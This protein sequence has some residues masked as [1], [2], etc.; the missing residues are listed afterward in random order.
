[1]SIKAGA[2]VQKGR[3]VV[4][5][6]I[7]AGGP[8]QVSIPEE[9]I[10]ELGNYDSV[11]TV[12]DT[13]DVTYSLESLDASAELEATLTGNNFATDAAGT[14]YD[15]G[16]CKP[17]DVVGQFKPGK[18]A[19]S[20]YNAVGCAIAPYLM[21]ES[22]EYRFGLTENGSVSG[23]L[24]G[25]S[26]FY[27]AGSAYIQTVGAPTILAVTNKAL[28]SNVATITIGTHSISV[29]DSVTVAGVDATFNGTYTV[30]AVTGTTISYAKTAA[31]VTSVAATGSVTKA[32]TTV[33]SATPYSLSNTAYPYNGDSSTGVRYTLSVSDSKGQRYRLGVDYTE[34]ASGGGSAKTVSI[35]LTG[36]QLP[37]AGH[38]LYI[39][40]ASDVADVLS[41]IHASESAARPSAIRGRHVTVKIGGVTWTDVQSTSAS[42]RLQLDSDRE[43][44]NDQ[45]VS[46]DYDEADVTG[47]VQIKPRNVAAFFTKLKQIT[48]VT[49]DYEVMGAL[50]QATLSVEI[51]I[52]SPIDGSVLKTIYCPDAKFTMPG[53]NGRVQQ[54]TTFDINWT[55]ASGTLKVYKGA[56]P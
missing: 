5:D 41:G 4:L 51:I 54:K 16:L 26:I 42:W 55:S 56:K 43:L 23:Q 10:R 2:I 40:Y 12:L 9:K 31:N 49:E 50:Q 37:G 19:A 11:G 36:T 34:S 20:P 1:M 15:L 47:Q 44:G 46:R 7:Q 18:D 24:R 21:P 14:E 52:K 8:G 38:Q 17:L 45:V 6:R 33:A 13:P 48:G 53:F 3:N 30:T 27:N 25:D 35:T 28:T 39:A 32:G 22:L 29:S